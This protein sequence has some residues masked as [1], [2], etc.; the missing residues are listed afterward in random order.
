VL[1]GGR[2]V[3]LSKNIQPNFKRFDPFTK[4][5]DIIF[6]LSIVNTSIFDNIADPSVPDYGINVAYDA[7]RGLLIFCNRYQT[8]KSLVLNVNTGEFYEWYGI[9]ESYIGGI[10][11]VDG[12][13]YFGKSQYAVLNSTLWQEDLTLPLGYPSNSPIEFYSS[14]LTAGEPS[15]EKQALQLKLFGRIY[16]G[17]FNGAKGI[18]VKHFKDWN[19]LTAITDEYYTPVAGSAQY[20]HKKRLDS[21]KVLSIS[22]GFT[23]DEGE[24]TFEIESMEV[25]FNPIQQGMKK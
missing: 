19:R 6:E 13:F 14:W 17:S 3:E 25:E 22:V 18:R 8:D 24:T 16:K 9:A 20:S 11:A 5:D 4:D 7:F 1:P 12:V 10:T 15:L 2:C 21:D 23:V